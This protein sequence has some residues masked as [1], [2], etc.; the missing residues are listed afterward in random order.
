MALIKCPNCSKQISNKA[1]LCPHCGIDVQNELHRN[2]K[3]Q[4]QNE[5]SQN[6]LSTS[7]FLV[8]CEEQRQ[9]KRKRNLII[10]I[11]SICVGIALMACAFLFYNDVTR[12]DMVENT[13]ENDVELQLSYKEKKANELKE[14]HLLVFN[15]ESLSTIFET[16]E[17]IYHVDIDYEECIASQN[18]TARFIEEESIDEVLETIAIVTNTTITKKGNRFVCVKGEKCQ[19]TTDNQYTNDDLYLEKG[20]HFIMRRLKCPSTASLSGYVSPKEEANKGMANELGIKGLDIALF[21]VDAQNSFGAMLE[22]TYFVFYHNGEPKVV[23]EH[24]EV[25]KAMYSTYGLSNTLGLMGY[26]D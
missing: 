3:E 17:Y 22:V 25:V 2:R 9:K 23:M 21:R 11:V 18:I 6:N 20:W 10:V 19:Q 15:D 16:L 5:L 14:E 1:V 7:W 4:R 13:G 24:E 12:T 8:W 26:Y